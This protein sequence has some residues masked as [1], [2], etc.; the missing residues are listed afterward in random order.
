M[1]GTDEVEKLRDE[2]LELQGEYNSLQK[3]R[4]RLE[5]VL[6]EERAEHAREIVRLKALLDQIYDITRNA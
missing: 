2:L 3:E 4:D 6:A 1:F 5:D